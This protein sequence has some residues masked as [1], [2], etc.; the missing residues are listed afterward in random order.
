MYLGQV[1]AVIMGREYYQR[2][3][4]AHHRSWRPHRTTMSLAAAAIRKRWQIAYATLV[5]LN[6]ERDIAID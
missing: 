5:Q 6:R 1:A 3:A 4:S 2:P